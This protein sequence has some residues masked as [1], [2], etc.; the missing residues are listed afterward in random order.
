[1]GKNFWKIVNDVIQDSDVLLLLLDA[2]LVKETRNKE[3]EEKVKKA[4][5]TLI[6][7]VTKSDLANKDDV[8]KYKNN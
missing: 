8:E 5:K 4:G 1:M 3:I 2:R 7:V 6:F